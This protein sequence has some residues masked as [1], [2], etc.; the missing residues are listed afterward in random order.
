MDQHSI[1]LRAA[2]PT[3]D[4]GFV[5]AR[6]LEEVAEGFFRFM[7]GPRVTDIIATAYTHPNHDYSYENV[8]FAEY[9][10]VI[11]GMASGFTAEQHR[12]FSD[13]PLK[14]AAGNRTLRMITDAAASESETSLV[15]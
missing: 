5:F 3:I 9:D 4:E 15:K 14:H 6:Y 7:L 11:V 8:T 12:R 1:I 13:Q 10:K 2:K